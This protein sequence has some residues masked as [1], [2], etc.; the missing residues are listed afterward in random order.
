MDNQLFIV[1]ESQDKIFLED[2]RDKWSKKEDEVLLVFADQLYLYWEILINADRLI[3]AFSTEVNNDFYNL[4]LGRLQNGKRSINLFLNPIYLNI[5]QKYVIGRNKTIFKDLYDGNVVPILENI[6]KMAETWEPIP[7]FI[8]PPEINNGLQQ[9]ENDNIIPPG[10]Q[11]ESPKSKS[12]LWG[13]LIA[14][15][16]I[17]GFGIWGYNAYVESSAEK[18]RIE[19]SNREVEAWNNFRNTNKGSAFLFM[20]GL[21]SNNTSNE[22]SS[23]IFDEYIKDRYGQDQD[24]ERG[25]NR[26]VS[27]FQT[28]YNIPISLLPN[29]SSELGQKYSDWNERGFT[30]EWNPVNG[31]EY[32]GVFNFLSIETIIEGK[33]V[34][35]HYSLDPNDV[36]REEGAINLMWENGR[37]TIDDFY[38][39][40]ISFKDYLSKQINDASAPLLEEGNNLW[41]GEM[42][43]ERGDTI[44]V[45]IV[46]KVEDERIVSAQFINE[47][48]GG[49]IF[50]KPYVTEECDLGLT[51][52][53]GSVHIK[54]NLSEDKMLIGK[55]D[56]YNGGFF[57]YS[58]QFRK[59]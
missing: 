16:C 2:V 13:C 33:L 9:T 14:I 29:M 7:E 57:E 15:V 50:L 3:I 11:E 37:W 25:I 31:I 32:A 35:I 46:I 12:K 28:E 6:I 49:S 20:N 19:S 56:E 41:E 22:V 59:K 26:L 53:Q 30:L 40:G 36:N 38:E 1:G 5:E 27:N 44:P 47:L 10:Y 39:D 34:K 58:I 54:L 48:E 24:I 4:S 43:S 23:K 51:N 42:I 21:L 8:L 55:Y 18:E 45:S 17:I 52:S